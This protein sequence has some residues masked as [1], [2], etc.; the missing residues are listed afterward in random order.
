MQSYPS[1]QQKGSHEP[2]PVVDR[3]TSLL[4]LFLTQVEK[5][6]AQKEIYAEGRIDQVDQGWLSSAWRRDNYSG[7]MNGND[8]ITC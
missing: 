6:P 4:R 1:A 8:S 7:T 5:C 2:I 3:K